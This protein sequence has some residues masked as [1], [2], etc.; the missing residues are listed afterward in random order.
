MKKLIFVLLCGMMLTGCTGKTQN[1]HES[2]VQVAEGEEEKRAETEIK[3]KPE[4]LYD[5]DELVVKALGEVQFQIP[6]DW[7]KDVKEN[8]EFTYYYY[9]S[10][11]FSTQYSESDFTND[12]LIEGAEGYVD[13]LKSGFDQ[14][15][16]EQTNMIE[17]SKTEAIEFSAKVTVDKKNMDIKI[18]TFCHSGRI[19]AF[20]FYVDA[21]SKKDYIVEYESFKDS[22]EIPTEKTS[23]TPEEVLDEAKKNMIL[24]MADTPLDDKNFNLYSGYLF[25]NVFALRDLNSNNYRDSDVYAE[26]ITG[27][28][29]FCAN[30]EE[31][32]VGYEIG[33]RAMSTVDYFIAGKGNIDDIVNDVVDV[34]RNA[35]FQVYE[36]KYPASQYKVG[37]D[38]PEGEYV[39]FADFGHGY[40][41]LT[42]DGNGNDII[43]NENFTYNSIIQIDSGEYLTLKD[44]SAVPSNDVQQLPLDKADMLKVGLHIEAG[45]Y[46]L[47]ADSDSAYYCIYNDSKQDDIDS[48][49]NFNGQS[50]ITVKDGQYLKMSR[51][52]IE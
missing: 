40:F 38:I 48:N 9:D 47:I 22:I 4:N 34:C 30:F 7:E 43:S 11:M 35:G 44:C 26:F 19:Y 45:E 14:C 32:S 41:A 20:A 25:D 12:E 2:T 13:G 5:T 21:D 42:S 39:L 31:G 6:A 24:N 16:E 18:L 1:T 15:E 3:Q 51:C 46:K 49:D 10:L 50:Y 29:F 33:N 37:V 36:T 28:A 8:G 23:V 52:H 27:A 17:V